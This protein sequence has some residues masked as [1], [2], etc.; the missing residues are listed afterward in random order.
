MLTGGRITVRSIGE[1]IDAAKASEKL[2]ADWKLSIT[3]G[4][5]P[6]LI[7]QWRAGKCWPSDARMIDLAK[8]A[9]AD[10]GLALAHLNLWRT[11]DARVSQIYSSIIARLGAASILATLVIGGSF[12]VQAR[13]ITEHRA[14]NSVLTVYY[15]K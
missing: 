9:G 15:Q 7:H 3:L 13:T 1:Y 11:N 12:S 5:S 14:T 8:L 4:V 10:P 2:T 6:T